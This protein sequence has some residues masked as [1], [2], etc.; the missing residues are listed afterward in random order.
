[1]SAAEQMRGMAIGGGLGF[2]VWVAMFAYPDVVF[3][4]LEFL[5]LMVEP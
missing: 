2:A 1:M 5:A 3:S 4:A